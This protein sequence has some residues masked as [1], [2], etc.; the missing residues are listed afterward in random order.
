MAEAVEAL[1][2]EAQIIVNVQGDEPRL[3]PA[4]LDRLVARL[5]RGEEPMATLACP[6]VP[7]EDPADPNLVKVAV[8]RDGRALYFSR[9]LIPYDRD[10]EGHAPP[11]RHLGIYAYRR[12]FLP[13][14]VGLPST[15]AEQAEKL[16]QLR[17]LEHG[18]AIAVEQVEPCGSG[19]DTR[20]QYEVFVEEWKA[21][22][23]RA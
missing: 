7:G 12:A 21:A 8:G 9:A 20:A 5:E 3:E 10:G 1:G 4:M 6:F 13:V 16:E 22:N 18:H 2:D 15:P 14:Y 11:L 17:A 23:D 19:I